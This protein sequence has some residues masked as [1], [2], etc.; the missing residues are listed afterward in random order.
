M[1]HEN[2]DTP[3]RYLVSVPVEAGLG[4]RMTGII[5]AF[6]LALFSR[7]AFQIRRFD[8]P[9]DIEYAYDYRFVH[10]TRPV[11]MDKEELVSPLLY[12]YKGQRG[13]PANHRK[14]DPWIIDT[15]R[16]GWNI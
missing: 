2:Y 8:K 15:E 14:Y 9:P 16:I 5:S 10:W 6:L 7:R 11:G 1:I 3:Q 4:D 12:I 13:Y